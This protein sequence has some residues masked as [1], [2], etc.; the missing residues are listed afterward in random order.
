VKEWQKWTAKDQ[1]TFGWKP[2][3]VDSALC[4]SP[5]FFVAKNGQLLETAA[6]QYGWKHYIQ[7]LLTNI[8]GP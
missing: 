7:P 3:Y 6:S 1:S 2:A 8:L 5:R 4:A